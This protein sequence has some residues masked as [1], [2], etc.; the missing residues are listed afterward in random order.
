MKVA[1]VVSTTSEGSRRYGVMSKVNGWFASMVKMAESGEV[2]AA[3]DEV[4]VPAAAEEADGDGRMLNVA[5]I[6]YCCPVVLDVA[7][8]RTTSTA[9]ARPS[10][11]V[12]LTVLPCVCGIVIQL[13]FEPAT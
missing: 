4:A 7:V 13:A 1:L 3:R 5:M 8:K 11:A 2:A 6:W 9:P 10:G 12:T